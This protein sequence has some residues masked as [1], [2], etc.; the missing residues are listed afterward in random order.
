MLRPCTRGDTSTFVRCPKRT[1]LG[2]T[3]ALFFVHTGR[4]SPS[5]GR[6]GRKCEY[7]FSHMSGGSAGNSPVIVDRRSMGGPP[8]IAPFEEIAVDE[9]VEL[10]LGLL[11]SL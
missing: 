8:T 9:H 11:E 2:L 6:A 3:F 1:A 5:R 10:N 4:Q 7:I